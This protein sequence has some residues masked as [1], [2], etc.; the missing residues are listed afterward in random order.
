MLEVSVKVSVAMITYNHGNFIAQAVESILMQVVN[1]DYEIIIGEDCSTDETRNVVI[2]YRNRFPHRIK[3]LLHDKNVGLMQ[4]FIQTIEACRGQYV[5]LCEGD[6]YWTSPY[7]LQK[8]VDFL[9][10]HPEY[11]ICFHNVT[12]ICEDGSEE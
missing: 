12:V 3:M 7:K 5:A 6:D 9:E 8:Q 2:E 4:N 10:S 11:A 1:F